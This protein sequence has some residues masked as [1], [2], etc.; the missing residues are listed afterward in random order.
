MLFHQWWNLITPL[1]E[2][3][4]MPVGLTEP[5]SEVDAGAQKKG[6][7]YVSYEWIHGTGIPLLVISNK[8]IVDTDS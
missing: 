2:S 1:A 4:I 7:Q 5:S 8:E 3:A 6:F